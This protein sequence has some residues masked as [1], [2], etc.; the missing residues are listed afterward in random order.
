MD[1]VLVGHARLREP[2]VS[3]S[4]QRFTLL[5][6]SKSSLL[7]CATC[8]QCHHEDVSLHP[9][10]NAAQM[11]NPV[12]LMNTP[13]HKPLIINMGVSLVLVG[14][15]QQIVHFWRG[16]PPINKLCGSKP[17]VPFWGR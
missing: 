11:I 15:V 10:K 13:F 1:V 17:M 9:F 16:T 5:N 3:P 2:S 12:K 4:P 8:K 7:L 6:P 14:I